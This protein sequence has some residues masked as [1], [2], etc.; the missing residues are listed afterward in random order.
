MEQSEDEPALIPSKWSHRLPTA[1][2]D[3]FLWIGSNQKQ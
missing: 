3:N 1:R 2:G